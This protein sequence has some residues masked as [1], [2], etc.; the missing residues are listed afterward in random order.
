MIYAM[1][2]AYIPFAM[3]IFA[4]YRNQLKELSKTH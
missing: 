4:E 1:I 3:W 2:S